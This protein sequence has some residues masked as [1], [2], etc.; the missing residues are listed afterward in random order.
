MIV[1]PAN[2]TGWIW[3]SLARETGRL[4]HLYSPGAQR[5]PWPWF[6]YA[7]DNGAF[8]CWEPQTNTFDYQKWKQREDEWR[9]MLF[10]AQAAPQKPL[11][12]IVPDIPGNSGETLKRWANYAPEVQS[13][14]FQ[15]ALAV[16]DG[17][18]CNDVRS[19]TPTPD[20]ICVG[21]TTE[22]K[23][24]T[25]EKWA[26][27]GRCHLLRCS[28]PERLDYLESLGVESCDSTGWNRGDRDKRLAGLEEWCR[29]RANLTTVSLWPF[30]C[31]GT[32]TKQ[33]HFA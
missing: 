9:R 19:L 25:V 10:W 33:M 13:C 11:W 21:G 24:Q 28:N 26:A 22:W 15:L 6:P 27:F 18:T 14:G 8:G 23:W 20:I 16:Q 5:G 30:A 32:D 29:K 7:L 1:M 4:G 31:R 2:C 3:H 17:M 12:A